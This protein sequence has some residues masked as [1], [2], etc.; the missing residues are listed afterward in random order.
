MDRRYW[1][2][3]VLWLFQVVNYFD[4]T[5]IGFAGPAMME[6]LGMSAA[7]FGIVLSSF[8]VGYALAQIP[9]GMIS[10]RW[11]AK[12]VLVAAPIGWAVF[13]GLTGLVSTLAAFVFVR[14]MLGVTE[15]LG[16][17]A[18]VKVQGDLFNSR[19]RAMM[20]RLWA[21][22]FAV[23]PALA[24]PIVGALLISQGW[25]SVFFVAMVPTLLVA[26]VIYFVIPNDRV[27]KPAVG[28]VAAPEPKATLTDMFALPSF[29]AASAT[30]FC[31]MVTFWG[32]V[33]WMPSYLSLARDIELKSMGMI[34]GV[35]YLFAIL[36]LLVFGWLGSGPL[37]KQ[38]IPLLAACYG[39][40]AL[41]LLLAFRADT[42]TTSIAGL[43]AAAFF[44]YAA[45]GLFGSVVLDFA[46]ANIRGSYWGAV[47]TVG[48]LAG[49]IAPAL[50][51]YLVTTTGSF[52]GGFAV[53][54]GALCGAALFVLAMGRARTRDLAA[55]LVTA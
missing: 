20:G 12:L 33:G 42:I 29:W 50:I 14:V 35:P 5:M 19:E 9:G 38:R 43:S 32:F 7:Q 44:I 36:G 23:G 13:T 3:A 24:G 41:A 31:F 34:A 39:F 45:M 16:N 25:R 6:S 4:R 1:I 47:S 26:A 30:W 27:A 21:T 15:G 53:M 10:D 51:G 11:G 55:P 8:A 54:I 49:V 37:F 48:Q 22:S 2:I 40:A 52:T 46:P 18:C 28:R 17:G